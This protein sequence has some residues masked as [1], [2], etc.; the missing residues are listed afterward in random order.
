MSDSFEH[1]LRVI[2]SMNRNQLYSISTIIDEAMEG[3]IT[4]PDDEKNVDNSDMHDYIARNIVDYII[5]MHPN[6]NIDTLSV[7]VSNIEDDLDS[8]DINEV[9]MIYQ[10][11]I[12]ENIKY[13]LE[14][15]EDETLVNFRFAVDAYVMTIDQ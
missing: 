8:M 5:N 3:N 11:M 10:G 9:D 7:I 15:M 4:M 12:R 1:V 13:K 6:Y 2:Q 14:D